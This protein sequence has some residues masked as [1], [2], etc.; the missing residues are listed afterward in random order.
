MVMGLQL[1]TWVCNPLRTLPRQWTRYGMFT[2]DFLLAVVINVAVC[3]P[4]SPPGTHLWQFGLENTSLCVYVYIHHLALKNI[5]HMYVCI[6]ISLY[7]CSLGRGEE[8]TWRWSF[9]CSPAF[10][11]SVRDVF[12]VPFASCHAAPEFLFAPGFF[13]VQRMY[14]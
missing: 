14:G 5:L 8:P 12:F 3:C 6:R 2:R 9:I 1:L 7:Y 4:D 11:Q 13:S 10:T